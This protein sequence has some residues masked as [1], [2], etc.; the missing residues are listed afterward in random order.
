[1]NKYHNIRGK[2]KK[3]I[4]GSEIWRN[5]M[6]NGNTE[7]RK[8]AGTIYHRNEDKLRRSTNEKILLKSQ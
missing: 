8:E 5:Q 4:R 3:R 7:F 1:M 6:E 2:K